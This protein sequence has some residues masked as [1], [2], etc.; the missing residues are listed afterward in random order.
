[1][2]FTP[3]FLFISA[4]FLFPPSQSFWLAFFFWVCRRSTRL[5]GWIFI[6]LSWSFPLIP[7]CVSSFSRSLRIFARWFGFKLKV[8]SFLLQQSRI[9]PRWP[10]S[11]FL[12]KTT[13]SLSRP[14]VCHS[15][16]FQ[17][18]SESLVFRVLVR[19]FCTFI[20][21]FSSF[22]WPTFTIHYFPT[23]QLFPWATRKFQIS[24]LN[25]MLLFSSSL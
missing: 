23:S 2:N 1:M 25:W 4:I 20:C 13:F 24:G 9:F 17:Q 3:R 14:F 21:V 22:S 18:S 10:R 5:F 6:I 8:L 7:F 16:R 15:S 19:S 11:R 12:T